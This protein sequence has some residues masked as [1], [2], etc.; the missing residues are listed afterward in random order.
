MKDFEK[1][2]KEMNTIFTNT[3]NRKDFCVKGFDIEKVDINLENTI[4]LCNLV[5][6]FNELYLKFKK[7]YKE[8]EKIPECGNFNVLSF[9][10]YEC[11]N[12]N[13]RTMT[14]DVYDD[15]IGYEK[16]SLL[17]LNEKDGM[18]NCFVTNGVF[19]P[20][21]EDYYR[22]DLH[23]DSLQVKK[24]LDIYEKY[25]VL[26]ETY[27]YFKNKFVFGD[28]TNVIFSKIEENLVDGLN[29]FEIHYGSILMNTSYSVKLIINLGENFGI[30]YSKCEVIW[31]NEKTLVDEN[32]LDNLFNDTR[33]HKSYLKE[34]TR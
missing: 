21:D 5:S 7:E 25:Q 33:I 32:V 1:F 3:L 11:D 28:G 30:D 16:A 24:Y 10:K 27:R 26:F 13:Y 31:D 22:E 12:V 15:N 23:L 29:Y 9:S 19:N 8:I 6:S 14:I 34:R 18:I 17:Y 2:T 4:S 20:M